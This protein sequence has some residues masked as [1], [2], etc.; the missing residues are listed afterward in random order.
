MLLVY[1]R[2]GVWVGDVWL[3]YIYVYHF[4]LLFVYSNHFGQI[5]EFLE[6]SSGNKPLF[7]LFMYN[8]PFDT[9]HRLWGILHFF[10][11]FDLFWFFDISFRS[12]AI[13]AVVVFQSTHKPSSSISDS[14]I[15]HL[16]LLSASNGFS[17]VWVWYN[18]NYLKCL[19]SFDA[20]R[21]RAFWNAI[22]LETYTLIGFSNRWT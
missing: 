17:F 18:P 22:P 3:K 16:F 10:S 15:V 1:M 20:N 19:Y 7:L 9:I 8:I 13:V 4:I 2:R 11:S 14:R 5:I 12:N 6:C 21:Q